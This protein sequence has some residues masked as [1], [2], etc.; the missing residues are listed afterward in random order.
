MASLPAVFLDDGEDSAMGT[1]GLGSG[2]QG[3]PGGGVLVNGRSPEH[4]GDERAAA[5]VGRSWGRRSAGERT[6]NTFRSGFG[7]VTVNSISKVSR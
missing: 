6:G 2:G 5:E 4:T 3:G 7:K 1:A